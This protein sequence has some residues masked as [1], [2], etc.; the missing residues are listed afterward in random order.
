MND[1]DLV[2]SQADWQTRLIAITQATDRDELTARSL[3]ALE[4]IL[5]GA[6]VGM[7]WFDHA[8][9]SAAALITQL[10][11]ADER[12]V[13][14]AGA[15]YIAIRA[16]GRLLGA[17][18]IPHAAMSEPVEQALVLLTALIG[19]T[20]LA[21][22]HPH[23]GEHS[24]PINH[25]ICRACAELDTSPDHDTLYDKIRQIT[26]R[27][28]PHFTFMIILRTSDADWMEFVYW[29]I[30]GQIRKIHEFWLP[31]SGLA[32]LTLRE[33]VTI[34]CES[35]D[36]ECRRR[37]ITPLRPYEDRTSSAWL[38]VPISA[39]GERFGVLIATRPGGERFSE[40][41]T[42]RMELI[43]HEATPWIQLSRRQQQLAQQAHQI[44]TFHQIVRQ[45]NA[46]LDPQRIPELIIDQA[47][48]LI[49]AEAGSLL[50]RDD[51]TG[52]LVFTVVSGP[53]SSQL[54]GTHLPYGRGI[55]G[56]VVRSG[57]SEIVN[58]T[59]SDGRFYAR[60]DQESGFTTR[61]VLAV[62]LRHI[63]GVKGVIE[64][65]NQRDNRPFNDADRALLE[66]FADHAVL[67]LE[68]TRRF[69][70]IDAALARQAHELA[71]S[72]QRLRSILRLSN[73][74][75][76]D[77]AID[78]M[79]EQ[80]VHN[81]NQTA[82][83]RSAVIK[84]VVEPPG[85]EPYLQRMIASG[86]IAHA[87][88]W[89]QSFKVPLSDFKNLLRPEFRRGDST[90]LID[91]HH[92]DYIELW[93]GIDQV[94][95]PRLPE[96]KP[97]EW[98]PHDTLFSLL[99]DRRGELIGILNVADPVD[100]MLP[101]AEQIHILEILANQIAATIENARLHAR[102]Q[103]NLATMTALNALAHAIHSTVKSP[104]QILALTASG[105]QSM[106]EAAWV[107]ILLVEQS[108][109]GSTRLVHEWSSGPAPKHWQ[110]LE[111]R[112]TQAI[113]NG[114]PVAHTDESRPERCL[115]LP[116]RAT[117]TTIGAICLGFQ[118]GLPNDE[119]IENLTIYANQAAVAIEN[120]RLL[121]DVRAGRDQLASIMQSTHEGILLIDADG[122]VAECNEAFQRLTGID[123]RHLYGKNVREP[124]FY[125]QLQGWRT[126][127]NLDHTVVEE[128]NR[129]FLAVI[130]GRQPDASVELGLA[131][132]VERILEWTALPVV[133]IEAGQP[134]QQLHAMLFVVRDITHDRKIEQMR[135]ELSSMI[136]HDLRSPLTSIQMAIETFFRRSA[137][138]LPTIQQG[139]LRTAQTSTN[140]LINLVE[141]L[142]VINRLESER[143]PANR[144]PAYI[145]EI[146]AEAITRMQVLAQ[147]HQ[148]TLKMN[149]DPELP[150]VL[151]DREL[152]QR[153]L[154][155]LIE[156]ALRY[157][158]KESAITI[159]AAAST[160]PGGIILS[161]RDQGPGIRLED[162]Q[163]I[164]NKFAQLDKRDRRGSGLGLTFCKLA[165]EAH[166]G[167]IRVESRPGAGSTF[168][169]D[170]PPPEPAQ[171]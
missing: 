138:D 123:R 161:V 26:A 9:D 98:H 17:L 94:F 45:I 149:V 112:A 34:N 53:L 100:R 154:Q 134:T 91:R 79:L 164:F 37:Q 166:G 27:F 56:D 162:Q 7:H 127:N 87:M 167:T 66:A 38:G 92:N 165:A 65:V 52:D 55:A 158:P 124:A 67:T 85:A 95:I 14:Y 106:S 126:K 77:S 72:N 99:L 145:A 109:D 39:N 111:D 114:R 61:S 142:L 88:P 140:Q 155:N 108:R 113:A 1:T 125:S 132:P 50:L 122:Y 6:A 57:K 107:V 68:N 46:S 84:L 43:A 160:A 150:P 104:R 49:G 143:M 80:V 152:I 23:A 101:S 29:S 128:M 36:A 105:M 97:G 96:P 141:T 117:H 22:D 8:P 4:Q 135:Q 137:K 102:Q 18:Q 170:I 10:Q 64:I 35:Y 168:I 148:I 144:R 89:V 118:H 44:N 103:R 78:D 2:G 82:G 28:V 51:E 31:T 139:I 59:H 83:Y 60:L 131:H 156:N 93:G 54:R 21:L 32:G 133:N 163:K 62:P 76:A 20:A 171:A 40:A 151:I 73:A 3:H 116:L 157:A 15:L 63:N 74:L 121:N 13:E 58:D 136:V 86:S 147:S 120:I 30:D 153:L 146:V 90:Y 25:A 48:E 115:A 47:C 119:T 70:D 81:I 169:V 42:R 41:D 16:A 130:E 71:Q 75:R 5:P 69:T 24:D 11:Q 33:G 12:F 159:S 19:P 129:R 110:E